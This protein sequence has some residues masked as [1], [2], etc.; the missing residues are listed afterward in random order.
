[1]SPGTQTGAGFPLEHP[2]QL[3]T[4]EQ[5][6]GE[7]GVTPQHVRL[8]IRQGKIAAEKAGRDW[9]IERKK[10]VRRPRGRPAKLDELR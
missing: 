4:T 7:L 5:A 10:L 9:L 2:L 3:L 1:L 6:A 8:L